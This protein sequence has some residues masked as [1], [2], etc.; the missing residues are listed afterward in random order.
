MTGS[1]KVK[2]VAVPW[3]RDRSFWLGIVPPFALGAAAMAV[4][5][6]FPTLGAPVVG[7]ILG[8]ILGEVLGQPAALA[9]GTRFCAKSVLQTS[10]VLLGAGMSLGQVAKIGGDGMPVMLGTLFIALGLGLPLARRLGIGRDTGTLVVY[11][12]S[13]CGASAI[14]TMS[15]V[16]GAESSAVAVSIAVIVLYNVLA[17]IVFPYVGLAL[18]LSPESFGLWAGTAVNDTSSV[19]AA[20]TSYDSL[21]L[22]AG[23]GGGL[24]ASYAVVVK[25]TRTL[26]IIPLSLFEAR[27]MQRRDPGAGPS[28]P[29]WRLIPTFLVLFLV[30]A[31]VRTLGVI[32]DAWNPAV[33][34]LAHYGTTVAMTAVGMSSSVTAIRKAGW[35]PLLLGGVLWVAIASSSL[36]L[37]W[38]T[39]RLTT[40]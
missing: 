32:P 27:R 7:I 20:A 2:S 15:L 22:M 36:L 11:G 13:I 40:G 38:A 17:A 16:I 28:K 35:R 31:G 25:L 3:F 26:A 34:F 37:Q 5:A 14:A 10:I 1:D 29:W 30:A 33:S 18:H 24:A 19:V 12:T 9:R 23:V 6:V 4:G 8:L 21:L 39:G